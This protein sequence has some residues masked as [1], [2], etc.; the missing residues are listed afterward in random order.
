MPIGGSTEPENTPQKRNDA[1]VLFNQ[2]NQHPAVDQRWLATHTLSKFDVTD[3]EKA[4]AAP[5]PTIDPQILGQIMVEGEAM[6]EELVMQIIDQALA[7]SQ[8]QQAAPQ[9]QAE[10]P[11]DEPPAP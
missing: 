6:P 1:M 2:F 9:E 3:V 7:A 8:Q 4:L 11:V 10:G 5:E